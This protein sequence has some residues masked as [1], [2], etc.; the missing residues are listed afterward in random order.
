[1]SPLRLSQA[2]LDE[3]MQ[4]AS[5]L[6]PDLRGQFLQMV[7]DHLPADPGD[8]HVYLACKHAAKEIRFMS[9]KQAI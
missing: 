8:G 3:V 4:T 9:M 5:A 2:Q 7:A 1:L 6:P